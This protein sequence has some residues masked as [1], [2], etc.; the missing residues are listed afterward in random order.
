[1]APAVRSPTVTRRDTLAAAAFG[2]LALSEVL[3]SPALTGSVRLNTLCV[4]AI[5]AP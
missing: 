5:A 1:M 2:A 4:V 3:V